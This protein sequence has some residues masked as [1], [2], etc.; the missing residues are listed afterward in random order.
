[1]ETIKDTEKSFHHWHWW[2]TSTVFTSLLFAID[3][4]F[5]ALVWINF[6]HIVRGTATV[7]NCCQDSIP[8]FFSLFI[9]NL[10][11]N[12]TAQQEPKCTFPCLFTLEVKQIIGFFLQLFPWFSS[13]IP[14]ASIPRHQTA[15]F[16]FHSLYIQVKHTDLN[17]SLPQKLS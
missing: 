17:N 7:S 15:P 11:G 12:K 8:F 3:A 14:R 5:A 16:S 2:T 9:L 13:M 4:G 10:I 6:V 1:M